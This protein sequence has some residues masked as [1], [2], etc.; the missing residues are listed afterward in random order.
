MKKIF[1]FMIMAVLSGA[2]PVSAATLNVGE[3]GEYRSLTEAVRAAQDGDE[4]LLSQG[5]YD[6]SL[7]E[8]PILIDKSLYIHSAEGERAA[9][10][11]P[12]L[13]VTMK[14]LKEGIVLEQ[15]EIDFI[16]YGLYVLADDAV[17]RN[18]CISLS[19]EKWRET[20]CGMWAGGAKHMTLDG[21]RFTDCGIALAGPEVIPGKN[22]VAVLTA[23]FE[24][25]EDIGFFDSHVIRECQVNEKPLVYLIGQKDST[26][27]ESCGQLIA[28]NCSNMTF[29]DL[30][31]SETSIGMQIAYSDNIR[32]LNSTADSC[33]VF[34]IYVCKSQDC[35]LGNI[36]ANKGA[37][38]IDIRDADCCIVTGCR[39]NECGQGVFYSWGRNCI[40]ADCEILD[41][42][43]GYFSAGGLHNHV[44]NCEI[45]GNELGLYIQHEPF[46][47]TD[48]TIREN[49]SCG[50]RFTDS[51]AIISGCAFEDNFVGALALAQSS[52]ILYGCSF[53]GNSE[54]AVYIK[55]SEELQLSGNT[56]AEGD[57]VF[58]K[59]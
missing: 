2:V 23:L 55:E 46:A 13:D 5:I 19:D 21:C 50:L 51:R 16:R 40:T 30:D 6:D 14:L 27:S 9:I 17:I 42:G 34:G 56:F 41:N 38:G 4:I 8:F 37:H 1:L 25:G 33:G 7:E 31:V 59:E 18:C 54:N 15:L 20:S 36:T 43:T 12:S 29:E 35:L 22:D 3:D 32:V 28:V 45:G 11:C 24:V 39:T 48:C 49:T 52:G 10:S 58:I 47:V 57:E 53:E 26:F 44:M